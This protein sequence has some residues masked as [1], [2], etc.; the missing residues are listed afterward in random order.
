M[1]I[2]ADGWLIGWVVIGL[3]AL[4]YE[5]LAMISRARR[6]TLSEQIWRFLGMY[7]DHANGLLLRRLIFAALWL[8]GLFM[9]N[10]STG[11]PRC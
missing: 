9:P 7:P 11:V 5:L 6:S 2:H 3:V 4:A 10:Y 1:V 8:W